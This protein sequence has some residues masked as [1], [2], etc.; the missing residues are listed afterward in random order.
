MKLE[1]SLDCSDHDIVEFEILRVGRRAC[2]KL[3][4]LDF[5]TADFGLLMDLLN[6][7]L[8]PSHPQVCLHL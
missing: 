8:F 6:R 7:V 4:T 1:G 5:R 3:A 2:S